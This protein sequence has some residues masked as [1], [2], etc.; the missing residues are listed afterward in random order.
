M[1][2]PDPRPSAADLLGAAAD[3][4][5]VVDGPTAWKVGHPTQRAKARLEDMTA[6]VAVRETLAL[7]PH[8][9]ADEF[10]PLWADVQADIRNREYRVGGRRWLE[11]VRSPGWAVLL[12]TALVREHHPDATED[13]VRGLMDREPEQVQA[14]VARVLPDFFRGVGRQ[15][16]LTP[17]QTADLE[18]AITEAVGLLAPPS[19]STA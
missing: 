6:A 8:L 7:K 19:G 1:P 12:L 14:A 11:A 16:R 5:A 9:S 2:D 13:D 10:A 15:L 17:A 4:P 18:R 3:P